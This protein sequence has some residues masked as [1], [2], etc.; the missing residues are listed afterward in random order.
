MKKIKFLITVGILAFLAACKTNTNKDSSQ[1]SDNTKADT[2]KGN[3]PTA[4][5]PESSTGTSATVY[6]AE[7]LY[8]LYCKNYSP[9]NNN[10]KMDGTVVQIKDKITDMT[11]GQFEV[12]FGTV[13]IGDGQTTNKI[14]AIFYGADTSKVKNMNPGDEL[15]L[16]G[17]ILD[18]GGMKYTTIVID[19]CKVK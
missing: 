6:K 8:T 17:R 7:D 13:S 1:A 18:G 9:E 14:R 10:P 4:Q 2:S 3:S 11:P 19:S 5:K 15:Y 16:E 12:D